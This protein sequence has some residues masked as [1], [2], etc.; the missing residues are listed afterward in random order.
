MT[1]PVQDYPQA[2]PLPAAGQGISRVAVVMPA[3]NED[4][5]IG[6]ALAS[7]RAAAD[8]LQREHP[9]V[10][11]TVTVVLDSCTDRSA[12][13]TAAYV[14][15]DARFAA[16]DVRLRSTGSSRAAG[17]RAALACADPEASRMWLANTDADS[18]VP[19]NWL[20][21]QVEL[22]DAGADAVLGSVEP[23]PA[24]MDP[25]ILRRWQE[26]H[27]F[28]ED[29]PHI[30]GANFG[31]R[32]SCYLA[33]GGFPRLHV[34]EDRALVERLRRRAFAVVATDTIRVLTSGRTHARAPQGFAAYLRA[35]GRER[36]AA[37][38]LRP[39]A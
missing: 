10:R 32:A 30:Y 18:S 1:G 6:R 39:P 19:E 37:T 5:H 16:V 4:Q 24:G 29:H 34:H 13:I 11:V 8:A 33:A 36:P 7:L 28:L 20:L 23:D 21:R 22:A 3:H 2:S 35:L 26:R 27:P 25:E 14:L 9:G 12:E 31:V 17:A 15:S 38:V